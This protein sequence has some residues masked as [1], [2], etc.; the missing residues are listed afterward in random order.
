MWSIGEC[1]LAPRVLRLFG[2]RRPANQKARNSGYEIAK[3]PS[4]LWT[5]DWT[6]GPLGGISQTNYY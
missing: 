2:Q 4:P 6:R 3:R 5:S 1:N